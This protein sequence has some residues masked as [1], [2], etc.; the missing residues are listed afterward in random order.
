MAERTKIRRAMVPNALNANDRILLLPNCDA[1]EKCPRWLGALNNVTNIGCGINALM[2]MGEID[3]NNAQ[4]GFR[5]AVQ[6]GQGTPFGHVVNWF[7]DRVKALDWRLDVKEIRYYIGTRE[8]LQGFYRTVFNEMPENSCIIVKYNRTPAAAAARGLTPGHYVVLSKEAGRLFT[9]EPLTSTFGNCDKRELRNLTVSP[10]FF[11]AMSVTNGYNSAS[12]LAVYSTV[13][14]FNDLAGF[15]GG[16]KEENISKEKVLSD[17]IFNLG[18]L[19]DFVEQNNCRRIGGRTI[20]DNKR[21]LS[22]KSKKLKKSKKSKK[23][24]KSKKS[25][26][27]KNNTNKSKK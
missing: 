6:G 3:E 23:L 18:L 22:K 10:G 11:N 17:K 26:K 21:N 8:N 12:I 24:K 5:G 15:T 13:V 27:L 7:N 9:Y 19:D 1:A 16:N 14:G 20:K 4:R 2:F 25:K